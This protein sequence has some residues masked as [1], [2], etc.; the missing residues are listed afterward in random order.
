LLRLIESG[1]PPILGSDLAEL[2]RCGRRS[3][4]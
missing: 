2:R 4:V 3:S 1:L